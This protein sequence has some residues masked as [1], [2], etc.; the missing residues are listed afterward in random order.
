MKG[1]PDRT[2]RAPEDF[3]GR[4]TMRYSSQILM[5]SSSS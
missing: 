5:I 3:R 1:G 2:V 4:E